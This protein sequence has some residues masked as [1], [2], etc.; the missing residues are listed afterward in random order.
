MLWLSSSLAKAMLMSWTGWQKTR[1][2]LQHHD[3]L[4]GFN[5]CAFLVV[6]WRHFSSPTPL[7][8]CDTFFTSPPAVSR[9]FR[10]H[11]NLWSQPQPPWPL[12]HTEGKNFMFALFGRH[13][14]SLVV[15]FRHFLVF[16]SSKCNAYSL[17]IPD[18]PMTVSLSMHYNPLLTRHASYLWMSAW[19]RSVFEICNNMERG[20]L[21]HRNV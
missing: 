9:R 10:F 11:T 16:A 19:E 6:T 14:S 2:R 13:F 21:C 15:N 7:L 3:H 1:G 5:V 12:Q 18:Y 8:G 20:W 17:V 4:A